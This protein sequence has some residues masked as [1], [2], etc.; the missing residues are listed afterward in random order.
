MR[1][2][3]QAQRKLS[4]S[5][6]ADFAEGEISLCCQLIGWVRPVGMGVTARDQGRDVD[7]ASRSQI[8]RGA[9]FYFFPKARLISAMASI[10]DVDNVL[11]TNVPR[12]SC[13]L[14]QEA[15]PSIL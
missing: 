8:M 12:K 13:S 10:W 5:R 3:A 9:A 15:S 7:A 6:R 1:T 14:S 4:L 2:L 11:P